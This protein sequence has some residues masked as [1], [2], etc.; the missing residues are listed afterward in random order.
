MRKV[1]KKKWEEI[2][3]YL[4]PA[5]NKASAKEVHEQHTENAGRYFCKANKCVVEIEIIA[6]GIENNEPDADDAK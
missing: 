1:Q 3:K 6:G 2:K 5:K 4:A